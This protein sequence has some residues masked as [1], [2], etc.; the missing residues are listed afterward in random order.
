MNLESLTIEQLRAF[1]V[2]AERLLNEKK[3]AAF[4]QDKFFKEYESEVRT[5]NLNDIALIK[6]RANRST[7]TPEKV[8][9][10]SKQLKSKE[11]KV[12]ITIPTEQ[13][14]R[15]LVAAGFSD[16]KIT[17]KEAIG[18]KKVAL[19]LSFAKGNDILEMGKLVESLT[20]ADVKAE[21]ERRKKVAAENAA[22]KKK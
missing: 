17:D 9:T 18:P 3:L 7:E 15:H 8:S 16:V 14:E 20:D 10:N 19:V 21:L 11:M 2:K 6:H 22:E 13:A 4:R 12:K 1:Q 5:K